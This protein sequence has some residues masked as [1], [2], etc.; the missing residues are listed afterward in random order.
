MWWK[1]H[2]S[3]EVVVFILN[4]LNHK[5]GADVPFD[6]LTFCKKKATSVVCQFQLN[7]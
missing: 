5:F 2:Q 7:P 6:Q 4:A 1:D 3:L